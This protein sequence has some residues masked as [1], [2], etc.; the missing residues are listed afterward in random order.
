MTSV[1][2]GT[3]TFRPSIYQLGIVAPLFA[4]ISI[5]II[6]GVVQGE[7]RVLMI[8]PVAVIFG[9]IVH[10][11][12]SHQVIVDHS[13]VTISQPKFMGGNFRFNWDEVESWEFVF[14]SP[15]SDSTESYNLRDRRK[16]IKIHWLEVTE[17]GVETLVQEIRDR[18]SPREI[19]KIVKAFRWTAVATAEGLRLTGKTL[20]N[21]YFRWSDVQSVQIRSK[22]ATECERFAQFSFRDDR[23]AVTIGDA[24]VTEPTW[25]RL[26][27]VLRD[28][29]PDF[30]TSDD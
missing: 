15:N 27:Q 9:L 22:S 25:D 18:V 30:S 24:F 8:S 2:S 16:P 5:G 12:L 29:V 1:C 14:P 21:A 13:G 17:P 6:G 28:H 3:R 19:L 7:W 10:D 11:K 4:F 23:P 26:L 20:N